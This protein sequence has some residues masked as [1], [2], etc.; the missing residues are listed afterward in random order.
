MTNTD[1]KT[2]PAKTRQQLFTTTAIVGSGAAGNAVLRH[3]LRQYMGDLQK[4]PEAATD[5]TINIYEER[6]CQCGVGSPYC[7]EPPVFRLNQP[8]SKMSLEKDF[9]DDVI[10]WVQEWQNSHPPEVIAAAAAL[11]QQ[12]TAEGMSENQFAY[13]YPADFN[14]GKKWDKNSFLPRS[15][16]G[17]YLRAEFEK[18]TAMADDINRTD[19]QGT[20][21]IVQH[22]ARVLDIR[23]AKHSDRL[24]LTGTKG[25]NHQEAFQSEVDAVVIATGHCKAEFLSEYQTNPD[26]LDTPLSMKTVAEKVGSASE[27][28]API[29]IIGTSQSMLD[30]LAALDAI[31]YKG[32]IIAFS[33]SNVE[34]WPFDPVKDANPQKDYKLKYLTPFNIQMIAATCQDDLEGAVS[35]LRALMTQEMHS[36]EAIA[37]GA[38]HALMTYHALQTEGKSLCEQCPGLLPRALAMI[39]EC[40]GNHT[41][42]ERFDLYQQ[43]KKEGRLQIQRGRILGAAP[44]DGGGFD[45]ELFDPL[46]QETRQIH[47]HKLINAA[48]MQRM[49]YVTTPEDGKLHACDPLTDSALQNG[50]LEVNL[51][52]KTIEPAPAFAEGTINLVGPVRGG[53]WGIPYF[54][55]S[56][57]K[58]ATKV[59]SKI[60]ASVPATN[61]AQK[62]KKRQHA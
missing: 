49:P 25:C 35:K 9:P 17:D 51:K 13:R 40:S 32:Q 61:R 1:N 3:M 18:T 55:K 50:L 27:K 29:V 16:Y 41:Y 11:L 20:V 62:D 43:Y 24:V 60:T 39:Q 4:S 52:T 56:F 47:A 34:P 31:E 37:C 36:P 45:V 42:S 54:K 10:N 7:A 21:N 38:S 8:A 15:F 30:A 33:A 44:A 53:T 57:Q 22:D 12:K 46:L 26:Y 6:Q 5:L 48:S 23:T 19:G 2:L 28:D 58:A 14:L 59:V